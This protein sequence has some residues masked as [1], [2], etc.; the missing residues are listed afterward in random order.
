MWHMIHGLM[1]SDQLKQ[2]VSQWKIKNIV[3]IKKYFRTQL[4]GTAAME[5]SSKIEGVNSQKYTGNNVYT[6]YLIICIITLTLI[7]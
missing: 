2:V 1:Q 7:S 3:N 6:Y 5:I 4:T